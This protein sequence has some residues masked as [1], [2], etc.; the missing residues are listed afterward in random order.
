MKN[1]LNNIFVEAEQNYKIIYETYKVL[2][3]TAEIK[4]S[5]HSAG[6]WILDNMYI[7]EQQ[8][9]SIRESRKNLKHLRLPVVKTTEGNK[10][11][12]IYYIAYELVELNTGYIDQNIIKNCLVEHQKT[13][14]LTSE[15]LELF[16]L[17]IKIGLLKF[18]ARVAM[19]ICHAQNQK[20]LVEDIL[21]E[22]KFDISRLA[23]DVSSEFTAFKNFK[24]YILEESRIKNANTSFV[25]YMAYR[26]KEL[27]KKGDNYYEALKVESEKI[28]FTIEEAIIKEH[29]EIAKT[30]D[31][32]SRAILSFKQIMGINF[33][34]IFEAVNKVDETLK[35]GD[36]TDEF[37]KCDYKTKTRYR[38]YI[39][40]LAKKYKVSELYVA[41]KAVDCS[42]K[43]KKHVGFFLCSDKKYL[44][45]KEMGKPY[46]SEVLYNKVAVKIKPIF[47]ILAILI[48]AFELTVLFAVNLID[49]GNLTLNI[50]AYIV[51]YGFFMEISE[52]I[53]NYFLRKTMIPE[54]L[55]RFNFAKTIS[56]DCTTYVINPTIISSIEKLDQMID[57]MEITYLANR[58]DNMYYM[59]I[60]DCISADKEHID[61]DDTMVA[62]AKEK[63][64]KLNAKYDKPH[65][66]FNFIYRKRVYS[67]GEKCFMGWER[68]RGAISEFNKL[69]LGKLSKEEI[70]KKFYVIYDDIVNAKYAITI[71]EDTNLSLN[72]AKDLVAIISHP[73]N[74][75][76]LSKNKKVVKSGYG[77]ICPA[78][79][80]DIEAANKTIFSKIF[81]GFGGL[82]IYTTAVANVYQDVFNEAIFCGKGAYDIELFEKLLGDTI[83]ENLV[84]SH[85]LLEGS[86]MRVGLASDIEVQ[87]GFPNNYISYMKRNHR[88]YRGDMQIIRWLISPRSPIN[89]LSK[90][91]IFDNLRRPTVY[92]I[93]LIAIILSMFVSMNA[94]V[95]TMLIVFLAINF[96]ILLGI[97]DKLIFGTHKH[98]KELQYIPIIHGFDADLLNMSFNL[99]NLPY[100][101]Y[102]CVNAFSK[103]L[104][105]ML[106]TR[107]HLLE[108][109]T[110]EV[111]DK[112]SKNTLGYYY[113]SMIPN[114][115]FG[116]FIILFPVKNINGFIGYEIF[117]I[118]MG[119]F[120]L[121]GPM[122][123]YLLGRDHLLGRRKKLNNK[124]DEEILEVAK[125]TWAFFDTLMTRTNNYLPTDNFQSGRRNKI[126]NRTSSTNI[127]F[128]ILAIIDAYDLKFID[129]EEMIEKL[130]NIYMTIENLEKW[131]GHLYNWYN[132]KTLEPLRPRFVSTVD[133][134]NFVACLY[135]AKS[136]FEELLGSQDFDRLDSKNTDRRVIRLLELNNTWIKNTDFTKLYNTSRNLFSIG[137]AQED[138]VLLDSY[139]DM[140]M[141]ESRTTSLIAIAR[142]DVTSKHWFALTRNMTKKDGYNGLVSW[143]GTAFEYYM[144][145]IF[146]K[147]YEHT[148]IDQSLFFTM[149]SNIKY[150]K[151]NNTPWGVSESAFAVKDSELNYQYQ[152]FGIPWLGLK[153]GLND[154]LVIAPYASILMLPFSPQKVYKNLQE[155][156]K[157][158][159]YDSYGFYEAIDFTRQNLDHGDSMKIVRTYMAHHQGMSL[160]A[161]NNYLN[162]GILQERFHRNPDIKATEILLKEREKMHVDKTINVTD[163]FNTFKQRNINKYTTH[164]SYT[165]SKVSDNTLGDNFEVAFLNGHGLSSI[166]LSNGATYLRYRDKIINKQRYKDINSTGNYLILTDKITGRKLNVEDSNMSSEYNKNTNKTIFTRDLA[167]VQNYVETD[168]IEATSTVF[169]SQEFNMEIRKVSLYNNS[170]IRR[171]I[172]INTYLELAM[173]DYMTNVVHP[174]FSN[175]QIE[176]YYDKDLDTLVASKRKKNETDTD[177]YVYSKLIGIDLEKGM[178]TEKQK[179]IQKQDQAYNEEIIKYPLWPVLSYRATIILEPHER[180]EFYYIV[181]ATDSRYKLTNAVVNLDYQE[182]KKQY[183]IA[184]ELNSVI[185]RYLKLKPGKAKVYNDI[186]KEVL[187]ETRQA[188]WDEFGNESINQSM[189]WKYSISGDLP[190]M[191]VY[192]DKIDD[193]GIIDEVIKFMDYVKNRNIDLD[194]IV[195]INEAE[196]RFGPIYTYIR[197][198]LDRAVYS[199]YTRGN[200]YMLNLKFMEEKEIKLLEFLT[201]KCITSVTEFIAMDKNIDVSEL[202]K[203]I[204]DSDIDKEDITIDIRKE[205]EENE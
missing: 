152:A 33:R 68:K 57:K 140:L 186:L 204:T 181:G 198:K 44:L 127:G 143:S 75:A 66:L 37:R 78:V 110:S 55:P 53:I 102:V 142:R 25:E 178:E 175:L 3:K 100:I 123:S 191:L 169:I 151:T 136:F 65:K 109:T 96:G 2:E 49:L 196:E 99:V 22:D 131:H 130:T 64:D 113:I 19:N 93:G 54:T 7:I 59:L 164:I 89:L 36:Y 195:L 84:L 24:T 77:I 41:K 185:A 63:L 21:K 107:K 35:N 125:R 15:E 121:L 26:L 20:L 60:G 187:F 160:C 11:V 177:F 50:I 48:L 87:D 126:V 122:F 197:T 149:Y 133:S 80:L 156:K 168:E 14:Y 189:L 129:Y 166:Y 17:M 183:K 132:I 52:K 176:T 58:S 46:F 145:Y 42:N 31:Y 92:V 43:Y 47:Y 10:Y 18:I 138:G 203:D 111:V 40:K 205:V 91:K 199:N 38:N 167:F 5:P 16:I 114:I 8:Y 98:I 108:W 171:E 82:D 118:S 165:D 106:F 1:T 192:V 117:K 180:Q 12:S 135:V 153:R 158:G 32:M 157:I 61:L 86:Y 90:W 179:L 159:A 134:G 154:Y 69:V 88:W 202:P 83:P 73:L 72:T 201:K 193:A 170:D 34:E 27:G 67:K 124:E 76:K 155:L 115:L 70:D 81:G 97:L 190:I 79:G 141:S 45:K 74:R 161:I 112:R 13:S 128:G 39:I 184:C 85:D 56:E 194:I 101:S 23:N 51:A 148:L 147:S 119:V 188:S 137:Y 162:N 9:S 174:A 95:E 173:T 28:G 172:L 6:Q 62:Y 29:M 71:D 120:M 104:F 163:K 182:I 103:S 4:L 105:R 30:T 139:Y 94:F 116:L 146:S 150:A 200:I 144:P